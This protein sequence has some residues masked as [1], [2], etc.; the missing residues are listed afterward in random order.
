VDSGPDSPC[1]AAA[2]PRFLLDAM[3]GRLAAWLRLLGYD[4]AYSREDDP[5]LIERCRAEGR[6]LLTRDTRLLAHRALP[7]HL[8]I[9]DDRVQEQMRQV[10]RAFALTPRAVS[11]RRCSRCNVPVEP[12]SHAEVAGL[13]PDFVWSRQETFWACPAC[14]RIYWAGSHRRRMDETLRALFTP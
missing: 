14:R 1:G 6:I 12:R 10:V 7:P 11:E 8:G 4:A 9:E 5:I 2:L 3:L 13:V